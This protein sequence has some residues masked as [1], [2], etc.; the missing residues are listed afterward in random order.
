[1]QDAE[2]QA[3]PFA[4]PSANLEGGGIGPEDAF[5][6]RYELGRFLVAAWQVQHVFLRP[7]VH[8]LVIGFAALVALGVEDTSAR[9]GVFLLGYLIFTG[10][11]CA[12]VFLGACLGRNPR[13]YTRHVVSLQ[14]EG[15]LVETP[16]GKSLH[17][18]RGIERVR[19]GVFF[20]AIYVHANAVQLV[21]SSAF[22]TPSQ[23]QQFVARL[24][25]R[26]SGQG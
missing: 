4:P 16:F 8:L 12:S 10:L 11:L 26:C 17:Y 15:L 1:M 19:S 23:Q 18:W 2:R 14:P 9:M 20:V 6:L 5:V 3:N 21:A 24:R 25:S 22:V 13:L 7:T